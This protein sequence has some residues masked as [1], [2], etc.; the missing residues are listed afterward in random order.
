MDSWVLWASRATIL[1]LSFITESSLLGVTLALVLNA[2]WASLFTLGLAWLDTSLGSKEWPAIVT[3]HSLE[4]LSCSN[5]IIHF[6]V[7][8]LVRG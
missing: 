6:T 1:A 5:A 3:I 8:R 4:M 7:L 2:G